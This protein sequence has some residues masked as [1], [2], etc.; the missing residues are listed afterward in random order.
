MGRLLKCLPI[1]FF[2]I[3]NKFF[4]NRRQ[5]FFLQLRQIYITFVWWIL[6]IQYIYIQILS[7]GISGITAI[8]KFSATRPAIDASSRISYAIFGVPPVCS[9]NWS[10]TGSEPAVLGEIYLGIRKCFLQINRSS[11]GKLMVS[12][13]NN[14]QFFLS[15]RYKITR[16]LFLFASREQMSYFS[17]FTLY[18]LCRISDR[19]T[20][21]TSQS[22]CS[23]KNRLQAVEQIHFQA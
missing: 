15:D 16:I 2:Y 12:W 19:K 21:F 22:S 23:F 18:N 1:A 13:N 6:N 14:N 9:N 10:I 4:Y 17:S 8:P 11:S 3:F 7:I 5:I 20:E